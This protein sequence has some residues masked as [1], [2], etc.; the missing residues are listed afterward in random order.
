MTAVSRDPAAD[1]A[2]CVLLVLATAC[3]GG[4]VLGVAGVFSLQAIVPLGMLA[5]VAGWWWRPRTAAGG[6]SHGSW[7]EAPLVWALVAGLYLPGYDAIVYGS[8]ATVYFDV[9]AHLART[10]ALAIAD[11]VLDRLPV[12]VQRR[13]FPM[14][15]PGESPGLYRSIA[16]LVFGGYTGPVWST[17]SALPSVWLGLGWAIGGE[18]GARLVTPLLGATGV[19]AIFLLVRGLAGRATA[20]LGAG[21]LAV[22]L[23]QVFFARLP[24][25]EVGGQVFLWLGLLALQRF[26]E[27]R[28]PIAALAGG[29]GLGLATIARL[30]YALFLPLALLLGEI[31]GGGWRVRLPRL[32]IVAIVAALAWSAVATLFLVPT[33]YRAALA[34]ALDARRLTEATAEAPWPAVILALATLAGGAFLWKVRGRRATARIGFVVLLAAWAWLY[35]GLGRSRAAWGA[36]GWLPDYIGWGAAVLALPG[37][38]LLVWRGRDGPGGRLALLLTAVAG[39]HLALDLHAAGTAVWAGRRLLPVVLPVICWSAAATLV[40]LARRSLALGLVTAAVVLALAVQPMRGIAGRGYW[41]GAGE[42]VASLAARFPEGSLVLLD[43]TLR[44]SLLDVGLWLVHD[45]SSIVLPAPSGQLDV[46]PGLLMAARPFPVYLLTH[47][48]RP[49]PERPGMRFEPVG[50][51]AL[52]LKLPGLGDAKSTLLPMQVFQVFLARPEPPAQK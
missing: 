49:A 37:A 51:G 44:E 21:L 28:A 10:G 13:I 46:V 22:A 8:D 17:F 30:E 33:H 4:L 40:A 48:L 23:P 1:A 32:A 3:A 19:T 52:R 39:T 50:D 41:D 2:V 31:A 7:W 16:G 43:A 45:R 47:A 6:A 15:V 34:W 36:L 14:A 26:H 24:M 35:V 20:L 5:G 27:T 25:A 38:I 29:A 9:G 12:P 18:T 11:P 42:Q